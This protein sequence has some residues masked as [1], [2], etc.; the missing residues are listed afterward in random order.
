MNTAV[1]INQ[2]IDLEVRRTGIGGSDI[3][4]VLGISPYKSA[5]EVYEEKVNGLT[6]DLSTN[7]KI[8]WGNLLEEPIA[9][10]YEQLTGV[11]TY[12]TGMSRH[13]KYPFLIAHPDRVMF[14]GKGLEIKA[15]GENAK[16]IW[17]ESGSQVIPEYYYLQAAHYMLVLDYKAWDVAALIGGQEL[18]IYNFERDKE[19]DELII[20]GAFDFWTNHVEKNISPPADCSR[21][22]V[23]SLI[24]RKNNLVSEE[25]VELPQELVEIT[26]K[27]QESK[28]LIAHYKKLQAEA[29]TM[30][31]KTIGTAGKATLPDGRVFYRKRIERKAYRVEAY[32]YTTLN[33]KGVQ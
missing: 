3:A 22:D 29:E 5:Y 28:E 30:I 18:R 13:S 16:H 26:N 6:Q 10:R 8:V 17:G 14:G 23:Q 25:V 31:L 32:N 33:L 11:Q 9:K 2:S 4:A 21:P 12:C 1:N 19:I 15:V 27:W 20:Q 7:E 24:R